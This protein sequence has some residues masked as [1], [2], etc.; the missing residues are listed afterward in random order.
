MGGV[1]FAQLGKL[2]VLREMG[3]LTEAYDSD[4]EELALW[5]FTLAT[6]A[7]KLVHCKRLEMIEGWGPLIRQLEQDEELLIGAIATTKAA[8]SK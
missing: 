3:I 8:V 6:K 5:H 1:D 4:N 2:T 7:E